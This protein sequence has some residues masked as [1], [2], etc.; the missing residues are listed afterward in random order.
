[1]ASIKHKS[2]RVMVWTPHDRDWV[3]SELRREFP[4]VRSQ[5]LESAVTTASEALEPSEGRVNLFRCARLMLK[6]N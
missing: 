4:K 1:M 5:A 6:L 2:T 3:V